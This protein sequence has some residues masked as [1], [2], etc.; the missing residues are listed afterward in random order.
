MKKAIDEYNDHKDLR[1]DE[2]ID[3]QKASKYFQKLQ[4]IKY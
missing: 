1:K 3:A 4:K 2:S